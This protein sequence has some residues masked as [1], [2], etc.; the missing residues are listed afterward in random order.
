MRRKKHPKKSMLEGKLEYTGSKQEDFTEMQSF[1]WGPNYFKEMSPLPSLALMPETSPGS[2]AW[3][4][5]HGLTN[6][7]LITE[8]GHKYNLHYLHLR[9]VVNTELRP[10][11]EEYASY[12]FSSF[13]TVHLDENNEIQLDQ[14]S[15]FL[16]KDILI[17]FRESKGSYFDHLRIKL[18]EADSMLRMRRQDFLLYCL[19]ETVIDNF[20]FVVDQIDDELE[21]LQAQ[22]ISSPA[23]NLLLRIEK[24]KNKFNTLRRQLIPLR[25]AFSF[26]EKNYDDFIEEKNVKYFKNLNS[27]LAHL[28]DVLEANRLELEG[29]TNINFANQNQRLN[30]VIKVLTILSTIFLPLTFIAGVYGMNFDNMPELHWHLGYFFFWGLMLILVVAMIIYFRRQ[31]W[32]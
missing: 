6:A 8:I 19:L 26:F 11:T 4:N 5:L 20:H 24:L 32:L 28:L 15:I 9:S 7:D 13:K 25:D 17:S 22:V 23:Y 29:L 3:L 10:R 2:S 31:K 1:T 14:V 12:I 30:E 16:L 21:I 18:R 27:N